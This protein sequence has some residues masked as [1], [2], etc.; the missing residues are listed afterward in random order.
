MAFTRNFVFTDP[1]AAQQAVQ[2]GQL[3][4]QEQAQRDQAFNEAFRNLGQ[5]NIARQNTQQQMMM[6]QAQMANRAAEAE[7]DRQLARQG[8]TSAETIAGAK[9][10]QR[11]SEIK[12]QND[13]DAVMQ[14][15]QAEQNHLLGKSYSDILNNKSIPEIQKTKFRESGLVTMDPAT[16][17]W[18]PVHPAPPPVAGG[19]QSIS[20]LLNKRRLGMG[21]STI[22]VTPVPSPGGFTPQPTDFRVPVEYPGG[23]LTEPL[24]TSPV[25]Q[26]DMTA[27]PA[28]YG[29]NPWEY[30]Y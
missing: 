13:Y 3:A 9:T 7:K 26:A 19:V 11:A 14:R 25:R 24:P 8:Y 18:V 21:P 10:A 23:P 15:K 12:A 4:N 17:L 28:A 6:N 5:Q 16:G 1:V 2:Y 22:S 20:D 30:N 27:P 29:S